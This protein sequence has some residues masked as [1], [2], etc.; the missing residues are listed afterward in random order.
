MEKKKINYWTEIGLA[1][2]KALQDQKIRVMNMDKHIH[3]RHPK[4]CELTFSSKESQLNN[5]SKEEWKEL[6]KKQYEEKKKKLEERP[7]SNYHHDLV[8]NLYGKKVDALKKS[9][10]QAAHEE[11]IQKILIKRSIYNSMKAFTHDNNKPNM[12]VVN[13]ENNWNISTFMV[14]PSSHTLET[15]R[16]IGVDMADK[17]SISM[18]NFFDIEIWEKTEY[19]SKLSGGRGNYRYQIGKNK[20][21]AAA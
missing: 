9:A 5:L 3:F 7:Y 13:T 4:L 8:N 18:K 20:Q 15:L 14:I 10:I 19:L 16:K 21:L 12:L 1:A 2:K 17:L 6:F 11:A